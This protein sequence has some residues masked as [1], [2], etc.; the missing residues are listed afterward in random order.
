[1]YLVGRLKAVLY[2][3]AS[4]PIVQLSVG[5]ILGAY[6]GGNAAL[7]VGIIGSLIIMLVNFVAKRRLRWLF[8]PVGVASIGVRMCFSPLGIR[9]DDVSKYNEKVVTLEAVVTNDLALK[10]DKTSA[11]VRVKTVEVDGRT[12]LASGLV[13]TWL[14]RYPAVRE[15]DVLKLKGKLER[16]QPIDGF[17][18][19]KFLEQKDVLSVMYRPVVESSGKRE[20]FVPYLLLVDLRALYVEKINRYLP[21]P[22]SSLVA[23]ILLGVKGNMP[24]DFADALANTGTT[25]IIAA[26]GYNVTIVAGGV[27]ALFGFFERR[28]RT[29]LSIIGIW[30]FVV[31][32]G[33]SPPVIRAG[34]MTT[35]TL[36]ALLGGMP[37]FVH[38]VLPLS[39]AVMALSDPEVVTGVSFQLSY[40]ATCGLVYLSPVIAT[41]LRI[42][43]EFIRGNLATT[44]SA[45]LVTLP[46][47]AGN[48]GR[49]SIIS[50][51]VNV[52]VLPCIELIM[53]LGCVLLV[54]PGFL[55]PVGKLVAGVLWSP[56]S[57]FVKVVFAFSSLPFASVEVSEIPVSV[58]MVYFLA[59]F[60]VIL[61]FYPQKEKMGIRT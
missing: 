40:L 5:I 33:L 54:V 10:P 59:I 4:I 16:P 6:L 43:P 14:S 38:V 61:R 11:V 58:F 53:G 41:W 24:P 13:Q 30:V 31:I 44:L 46:V 19:D 50:P 51:V 27:S 57:F 20:G 56:V 49:I 48:F 28:T 35:A 8:L 37:S 55:L 52:L 15:G 18:Y 42:V 32:A 47:I 7:L 39:G 22:H 34:I 3:V 1:M 36:V 17:A 2:F 9:E 23:G 26:S 21:E 25:H 45:V 12:S 29:I 60:L